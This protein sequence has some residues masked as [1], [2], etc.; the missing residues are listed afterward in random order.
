MFSEIKVMDA[1]PILRVPFPRQDEALAMLNRVAKQVS[2]IM[3]KRGWKVR[4]LIE[5]FPKDPSLQG[6][7][8]NRGELIALRLRSHHNHSTFL[9]WEH[10]LGTMLHEL[11]HIIVGPHNKDFYRLL[12]EL[13]NECDELQAR[14]IAG[15]GPF[16]CEGFRSGGLRRSAL[17]MKELML[18]KALQRQKVGS[19]MGS[20]RLGGATSAASKSLRELAAEAAERR[21]RTRTRSRAW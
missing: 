21:A 15:L 7:N 2:P 18:Q 1:N 10:I 14:G 17:E 11:S 8:K 6:Y 3:K 5:I 9:S 16:E 20:G 19:I 13:S 4:S 12:D